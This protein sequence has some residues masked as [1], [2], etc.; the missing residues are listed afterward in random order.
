MQAWRF[1][2]GCSYSDGS[3]MGPMRAGGI[4]IIGKTLTDFAAICQRVV[5]QLEALDLQDAVV[6]ST[7]AGSVRFRLREELATAWAPDC[8]TTQLCQRLNLHPDRA[9]ADLE[10]EILVAMLL[11]PVTFSFP[12]AEELTSGVKIRRNIV[13]AARKTTLAFDT[14][15]AERPEDCWTYHE[16]SGFTILPGK[17]LITALQKATQPD[18][19]GRLFSFSCYRATEYVILLAISQELAVC[20]PALL[21]ELQRLSE[22]RAIMSGE[23]HEVFLREYGSMDQPLPP[24]YYVPGDRTWFRNPD[25]R[26]SDIKGYEGSWV[27]YLGNG[28]FTN[29]WKRNQAYTLTSKCLE[30]FHWAD[31]A[32]TDAAGN[33]QMDESKVERLVAE[34]MKDPAKVE[35]ILASMQRYR[36]PSGVYVDGGCIDTTR[37][38]PRW[39]LP[40]TADLVVPQIKGMSPPIAT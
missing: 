22:V 4:E 30:L 23:F 17:S 29:F 25:S 19:S 20:N 31:A 15:Q 33:L 28:L 34:T 35:S 18:E 27:F 7:H 38:C 40:G 24:R 5:N 14:V 8:D 1:L 3:M 21:Q 16:A 36:E 11:G 10:K 12:S 9:D 13:K 39:I 32:V 26:S 6:V 37:E 2:G